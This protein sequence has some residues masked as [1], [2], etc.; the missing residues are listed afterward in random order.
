MSMCV[1]WL[2]V[3]AAFLD[4]LM[5]VC[6]CL[7]A[8]LVVLCVV[9]LCPGLLRCPLLRWNVPLLCSCV[10]V[11]VEMVFPMC[12]LCCG[13]VSFRCCC[14]L[15]RYVAVCLYG[16]CE[17]AKGL[18][19]HVCVCVCLCCLLVLYIYTVALSSLLL[20]CVC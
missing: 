15:P 9:C 11:L 2:R 10:D 17:F 6:L 7:C 4:E 20:Q 12:L 3:V 13:C 18:W 1:L 19:L 16:L 14:S 5:R 8:V